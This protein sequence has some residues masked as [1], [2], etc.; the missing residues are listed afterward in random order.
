MKSAALIG[1]KS[2]NARIDGTLRLTASK[3]AVVASTIQSAVLRRRNATTTEELKDR[4][5]KINA[6]SHATS[7]TK[8]NARVSEA[9]RPRQKDSTTT[10]PARRK[11]QAP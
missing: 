8:V 2:N 9:G 6:E 10:V 5:T 1:A 11:T 4:L 7:E 3:V